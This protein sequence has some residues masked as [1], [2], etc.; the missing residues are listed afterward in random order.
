MFKRD[1]VELEIEVEI[2]SLVD[3][4]DLEDTV[5]RLEKKEGCGGAELGMN[6]VSS[7]NR[8]M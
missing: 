8:L 3:I 1:P 5:V 2:D 7:A 6:K 4:V